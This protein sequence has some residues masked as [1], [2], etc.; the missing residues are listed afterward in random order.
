MFAAT[1]HGTGSANSSILLSHIEQWASDG[2]TVMVLHEVLNISN[3]MALGSTKG[4]CCTEMTET[5]QVTISESSLNETQAKS[6]NHM[7]FIIIGG[8][9]AVGVVTIIIIIIIV[10]VAVIV[11][12]RHHKRGK[13]R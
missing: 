1:I 6:N 5:R 8:G 10:M 11:K 3:I 9:S 13:I 4:E 12:C 7:T 2:A